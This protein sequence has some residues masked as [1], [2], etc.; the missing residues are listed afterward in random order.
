MNKSNLIGIILIGVVIVVYSV[1]LIPKQTPSSTPISATDTTQVET[2]TAVATEEESQTTSDAAKPIPVDSLYA[3]SQLKN[4]TAKEYT[5]ENEKLCVTFSTQGAMPVSAELT[6]YLS[7]DS[8]QVRLFAPGDFMLN[9]P[10]RTNQNQI[11]ETKDLIWLASQPNDSTILMTLPIDS[12]SYLR[13]IYTMPHEGYMLGM[14]IEAQGLGSLL[15]SNNAIQDLEMSLRIP[16]QERSWKFENQYSTI[17]YKYPADDVEKLKE[18]KM[19]QESA[20]RSSG[21]Q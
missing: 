1:F 9:L 3:F 5:L 10:L 12:S 15:Q 4:Q 2:N 21:W 19:V 17:Y 7:Y 20:R 16:R 6:D 11:L 14:A 18:T 8:T 13:I